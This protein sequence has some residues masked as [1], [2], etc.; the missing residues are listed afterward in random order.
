MSE[1]P[2]GIDL[3]KLPQLTPPR[4]VLPDVLS[5]AP[6]DTPVAPTRWPVL[7]AAAVML[8]AAG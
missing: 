4:D 1:Q 5:G 8:L 6:A 2:T 7:A 3:R